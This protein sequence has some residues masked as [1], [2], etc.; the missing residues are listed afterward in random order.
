VLVK[1]HKKKYFV[2]EEEFYESLPEEDAL[3][4]LNDLAVAM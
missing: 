4:V 1:I 2:D 3:P